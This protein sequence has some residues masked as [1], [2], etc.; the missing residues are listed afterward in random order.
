MGRA[1][2]TSGNFQDRASLDIP[3]T[4]VRGTTFRRSRAAGTHLTRY[5]GAP[6][7]VL[8][9]EYTRVMR[10]IEACRATRLGHGGGRYA[11]RGLGIHLRNLNRQRQDKM[12]ASLAFFAALRS[13]GVLA[14]YYGRFGVRRESG[15]PRGIAIDGNHQLHQD[16]RRLLEQLNDNRALLV[17]P[18]SVTHTPYLGRVEYAAN[19]LVN[20]LANDDN[21]DTFVRFIDDDTIDHQIK[22]AITR[23]YC[24]SVTEAAAQLAHTVRFDEGPDAA[25]RAARYGI[26]GMAHDGIVR[27]DEVERWL[28]Q[29]HPNLVHEV[30][31]TRETELGRVSLQAA[32]DQARGDADG[33]VFGAALS[34]AGIYGNV[35]GN[36]GFGDA[37]TMGVAKV[38]MGRI[39]SSERLRGLLRPSMLRMYARFVCRDLPEGSQQIV[40]TAINSPTSSNVELATP[41]INN[42]YQTQWGRNAFITAV[43]VVQFGFVVYGAVEDG[44]VEATEGLDILES[45][46]GASTSVVSFLARDGI[47][48]ARITRAFSQLDETVG[49]L[50]TAANRF[51]AV[52]A[53]CR[54]VYDLNR[55]IEEDD[56]RGQVIAGLT[57]ASGLALAA[58]AWCS[59]VPGA[60]PVGVAL[61]ILAAVVGL[62]GWAYD[63]TLPE[64]GAELMLLKRY[65]DSA[66][67]DQRFM[68]SGRL[69]GDIKQ[70]WERIKD[71]L[72]GHAYKI[73]F[74]NDDSENH[75]Q[76][77]RDLRAVG[78]E[79]DLAGTSD[80][81]SIDDI[82]HRM[83]AYGF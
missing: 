83:G 18:L 56:G 30:D 55:A 27:A 43:A 41:H 15:A 80:T 73:A 68:D 60:Q 33:G 7:F 21:R 36:V 45:G 28:R 19:G 67:D 38:G 34:A 29:N 46:V 72:N 2:I 58:G 64:L 65:I 59:S 70:T 40:M 3:D 62:L 53:I 17:D 49:Q 78:Y 25:P 48:V 51:F 57:A 54:G 9:R 82:I 1:F 20:E 81:I 71:L 63:Q 16:G 13:V 77:V 12:E 32:M 39:L 50:E 75:V 66:R 22:R 74:N 42:N 10:V 52:V 26:G 6:M 8:S 31:Q 24:A 79:R 76:C 5:E 69:P 44:R 61:G 47:R 14:D 37:F 23:V 35:Y 11:H 4:W